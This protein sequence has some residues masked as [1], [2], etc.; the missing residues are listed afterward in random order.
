V[1]GFS[2]PSSHW[3]CSP[4]VEEKEGEA[5]KKE[6]SGASTSPISPGSKPST[7]VHCPGQKENRTKIR[8]EKRMES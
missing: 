8:Q 4:E 1:T 3:K 5:V 6:A 2:Y 7:W